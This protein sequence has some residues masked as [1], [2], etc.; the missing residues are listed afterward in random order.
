MA[1]HSSRPFCTVCKWHFRTP[2]KFVE[3][4]KSPE[5]KQRVEELRNEGGPE[6]PEELIT[7]DAIGCFEGEEDYEEEPTEGEEED[8]DSQPSHSQKVVRP[9]QREVAL[10]EMRDDEEYDSETQ[11][12]SSFVVPVAGFLCRLCHKFYHFES[13]ARLSH[14]KSQMHFQNLQ[15][16]RALKSQE[17]TEE[18]LSE[19]GEPGSSGI[20]EDHQELGPAEG[21]T[22]VGPEM[23]SVGGNSKN[24]D[25][26]PALS[27]GPSSD[28]ATPGGPKSASD[29]QDPEKAS[30][31]LPNRSKTDSSGAAVDSSS[32]G[33]AQ[34]KTKDFSPDPTRSASPP[35][36]LLEGSEDGTSD[37]VS[38]HMDCAADEPA[39]PADDPGNRSSLSE[40]DGSPDR[41]PA[42]E[43]GE[44]EPERDGPQVLSGQAEKRSPN[45]EGK[46]EEAAREGE[47]EEDEEAGAGDRLTAG[48]SRAT[49][50]R[51]RSTRT[52]RRR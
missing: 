48:R 24:V 21:T 4:M 16:Y 20:L 46:E 22:G 30:S 39:Q 35:C 41:P 2:R 6:I 40:K 29:I 36:V 18:S 9:A 13:T 19:A 26:E 12:G 51:R 37:S 27:L 17:E 10:E 25:L 31:D 32:N 38:S 28:Q 11:Y 14:C 50:P 43:P 42:E 45:A 23:T 3:H 33:S 47:E 5:H 49:A 1:K 8:E 52:T 34:S 44:E 15:K 7:V